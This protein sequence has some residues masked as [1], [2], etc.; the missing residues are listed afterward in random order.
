MPRL[1]NMKLLCSKVL[2]T[3]IFACIDDSTLA[4]GTFRV[5]ISYGGLQGGDLSSLTAETLSTGA[6]TSLMQLLHSC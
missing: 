3:V 6:E 1:Q 2:L 4:C 5:E